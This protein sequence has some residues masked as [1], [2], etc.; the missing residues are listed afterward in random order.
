[1]SEFRSNNFRSPYTALLILLCTL[2][3]MA[4]CE[5]S[6]R[7]ASNPN[8]TALIDQAQ[9]NNLKFSLQSRA[10][11]KEYG[12]LFV[13]EQQDK[14]GDWQRIYETDFKD[15]KPWKLELGDVDGDGINEILI[16][17]TK[18]THFDPQQK[19]RMFI[20]NFNGE[21]LY[22]KWTGSQ[23][24]GQWRDFYVGDL[25][26]IPGEELIFIEQLD[27]D[28]DRLSIYYWLDFGFTLLAE[29][30][31]YENIRDF[32]I[33]DHNSMQFTYRFEEEDVMQTFSVKDGKIIATN[34][35]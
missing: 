26:S 13:V 14:N 2:T 27:N 24:A 6:E 23:I 1:M 34:A 11:S 35:R 5:T 3:M 16:A 17:V 19:N 25:L 7:S 9:E 31:S 18:T 12:D 22:K 33:L 21:K 20:F 32:H 29:S 10:S 15:L 30:D 8:L 28:H 4:G